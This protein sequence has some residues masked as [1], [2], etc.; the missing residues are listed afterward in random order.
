MRKIIFTTLVAALAILG[1]TLT[2]V[3][4]AA[5]HQF[6]H[7]H[8]WIDPWQNPNFGVMAAG[9]AAAGASGSR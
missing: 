2:T 5:A 3:G 8:R 6:R 4:D 7:F 9:L 1:T